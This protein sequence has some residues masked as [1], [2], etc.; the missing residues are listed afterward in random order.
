MILV[1]NLV[2]SASF[3]DKRKAIFFQ[4]CSGE[5]VVKL[6]GKHLFS[7]VISQIFRR[8][9]LESLFNKA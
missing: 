6:Q 8:N 5:N 3:C 1:A 2:P 4:N 7:K 9:L